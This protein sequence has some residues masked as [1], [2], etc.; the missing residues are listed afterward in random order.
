MD[1]RIN[2]ICHPNNPDLHLSTIVGAITQFGPTDLIPNQGY[3]NIAV[4]SGSLVFDSRGS[5]GFIEDMRD[6]AGIL[7]PEVR[8]VYTPSNFDTNVVH[9]LG[10]E[11]IRGSKTFMDDMSMGLKGIHKMADPIDITDATTKNYV[12]SL[13]SLNITEK[14]VY[15]NQGSVNTN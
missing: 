12:D 13:L 3:E 4:R 14:L 10:A 6:I 15:S 2:C 8:T 7:V 5:F 11:T 1:V 9:T